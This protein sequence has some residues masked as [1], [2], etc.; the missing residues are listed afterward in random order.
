MPMNSPAMRKPLTWSRPSIGLRM[1][2]KELAYRNISLDWTA[3]PSAQAVTK[4]TLVL[5]PNRVQTSYVELANSAHQQIYELV[6][7]RSVLEIR[8]I[9]AWP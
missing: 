3:L 8:Y 4:K 1:V 2:L 9:S 5:K 6:K 7:E